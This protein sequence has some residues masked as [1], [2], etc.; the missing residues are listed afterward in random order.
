MRPVSWSKPRCCGDGV[1]ELSV[2]VEPAAGV[3]LVTAGTVGVS[4]TCFEG[5]EYLWGVVPQGSCGTEDGVEAALYQPND[6]TEGILGPTRMLP[7]SMDERG[8]AD[9]GSCQV[10]SRGHR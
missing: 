10:G 6:R 9:P 2:G 3:E 5:E 7:C 8:V 1:V 4:T